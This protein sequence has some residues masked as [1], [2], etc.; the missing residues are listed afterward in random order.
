M[1]YSDLER[2]A[3]ALA[4]E[5]QPT[6]QEQLENAEAQLERMHR[7]H[8]EQLSNARERWFEAV[9]ELE[10]QRAAN[11]RLLQL[12]RKYRAAEKRSNG[13]S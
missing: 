8:S 5:L 9:N 3:A 6:L 11:H 2:R 7:R 12:L 4:R 1:G 13:K 10:I